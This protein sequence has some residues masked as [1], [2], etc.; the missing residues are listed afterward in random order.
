[1]KIEVPTKKLFTQQN[2]IRVF[3]KE[4]GDDDESALVISS[5]SSYDYKGKVCYG[6]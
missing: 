1:M 6:F 2:F 3:E 5:T 4:N